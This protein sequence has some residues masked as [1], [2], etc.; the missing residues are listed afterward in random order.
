MGILEVK[1]MQSSEETR[2]TGDKGRVELVKLGS[3]T[4]G[5]TVFQPG[6]KWSEHVKPV[7]GTDSC[8]SHHT[9]YVVSGRMHV[10]TD[11]G[12]EADLGPGDAIVIGPGHDAWVVGDEPFVSLDFSGMEKYALPS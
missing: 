10:V 12:T 2:L 11:E 1:S 5:R 4:A 6:W 8:Q 7:A 3:V 9:G